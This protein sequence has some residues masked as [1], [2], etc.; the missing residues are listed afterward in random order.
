M[1]LIQA[2]FTSLC[3]KRPVPFNVILPL[4]M[5]NPLAPPTPLPLKTLYLL[6]GYTQSCMDWLTGSEVGELAALYGIAIVMPDA[7]NHFYVDDMQRQDMY[8]EYIGRELVDFTRRM[9][10]LS[11]RREDT[12]IGGISMGGFGAL[13]NGLKYSDVF[14]HIIAI[15]PAIITDELASSTD[16]PNHVGATRGYYESVFGDLDKVSQSDMDLVWLT[17][18]MAA[19]GKAFPDI[20]LACGN[21]DM[22]VFASR[23]LHGHLEQLGIRH[24]YEEGSGSHEPLFFNPHLRRG[25]DCLPL[26]KPPEM[27]NPFWI[28]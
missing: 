22:L 19:E 28:D 18:K 16:A 4:D 17:G 23:K 14:S 2:N 3:L 27:P 26:N 10:P 24:V 15:S 9:F 20:Y 13:R 21:N 6:H 11:H 25:L 1:A 7:E 12:F 8:G 5:L